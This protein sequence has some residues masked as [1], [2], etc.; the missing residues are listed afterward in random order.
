LDS[1]AYDRVTDLPVVGIVFL[2]DHPALASLDQFF[3]DNG[4]GILP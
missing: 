3:A 2:G 4:L 1:T